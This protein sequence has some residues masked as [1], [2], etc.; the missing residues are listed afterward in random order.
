MF[1]KRHKPPSRTAPKSGP[2]LD[3]QALEL[4]HRRAQ[5][6]ASLPP[7]PGSCY[8]PAHICTHHRLNN[9]A[10][11]HARLEVRVSPGDPVC[12]RPPP[13]ARGSPR[14]GLRTAAGCGLQR[15]P[16]LARQDLVHVPGGHSPA[17]A[18]LGLERG[19]REAQRLDPGP[20]ALLGASN[21]GKAGSGCSCE[22]PGGGRRSRGKQRVGRG[23]CERRGLRPQRGSASGGSLTHHSPAG[24]RAG[25]PGQGPA[26]PPRP[27]RAGPPGALGA[28]V[29]RDH[30]EVL[31]GCGTG[32]DSA[33]ATSDPGGSD[34]GSCC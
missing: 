29:V 5:A 6:P 22:A 10:L 9:Y 24:Q 30:N 15:P 7:R 18:A 26:E 16:H 14:P 13:K 31:H 33:R 17:S 2:S 34:F 23:L 28:A 20:G 11:P 25:G 8:L 19:A 3:C 1:A 4:G 32:R 12:P 21:T 27:A